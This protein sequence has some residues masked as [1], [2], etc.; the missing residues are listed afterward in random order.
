MREKKMKMN[1]LNKFD[2]YSS[3]NEDDILGQHKTLVVNEEKYKT[4]ININ[5]DIEEIFK[6]FLM[7]HN[8]YENPS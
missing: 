1:E 5:D 2:I 7:L 8:K 3:D 6:P 4:L